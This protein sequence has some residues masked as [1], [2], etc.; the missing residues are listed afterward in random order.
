MIARPRPSAR[1]AQKRRG[2]TLIELLVVISI[3]A[4]LMSLILPAVQ[5]ARRAARRLECQNNVKQMVL[6]IHNVATG[7]GDKLPRLV[8]TIQ[9]DNPT[10]GITQYVHSWPVSI[11]PALDN[12]ALYRTFRSVP[13]A[14]VADLDA[15][16]GADLTTEQ[17][18]WI[19]A[20]TCPDDQN[21]H[22]KS[23]GLSYVANAG[24]IATSYFTDNQQDAYRV[25]YNGNGTIGDPQDASIAYATGV[26]WRPA[27]MFVGTAPN[28]T[29]TA[30]MNGD[31]FRASLDYISQSDGTTSTIMIGENITAGVTTTFTYSGNPEQNT[32][33]A[34]PNVQRTGFGWIIDPVV[35][36]GQGT[37][38]GAALSPTGSPANWGG[39]GTT[40]SRINSNLASTSIQPRLS[41]NHAGSLNVGMCDGSVRSLSENMD[42]YVYA[43]LLTPDGRRYGQQIVNQAD[44]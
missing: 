29:A 38:T 7:N 19:K 13:T 15:S 20:F 16:G 6:A 14:L 2:F 35:A 5:N 40:L 9:L 4:V 30:A 42:Q 23:L 44:Y 22:Q 31:T 24:Y 12:A 37:N 17:R 34:S 39:S 11:L 10:G 43:R 36:A 41:S 25:D 26:F 32:G 8:D 33:W 21:N 3:I 27:Q 28:A 1:A 18:I